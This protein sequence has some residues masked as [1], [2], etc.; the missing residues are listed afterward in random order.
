MAGQPLRRREKA[1]CGEQ[2]GDYQILERQMSREVWHVL[3]YAW[4][5][6]FFPFV[7]ISYFNQL[8]IQNCA[9]VWMFWFQFAWMIV[10]LILMIQQ[11]N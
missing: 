2:L 10:H 1:I 6:N 4:I 3:V 9:G 8:S 11:D 5:L 7:S